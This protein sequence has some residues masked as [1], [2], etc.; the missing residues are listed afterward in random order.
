MSQLPF[1]SITELSDRLRRRE[2]RAVDV[3]SAMLERIELIDPSTKSYVHVCGD[4]AL[5]KADEADRQMDMGR[6]KGVLHGVPLGVKDL[7]HTTFAPTAAGGLVYDGF[8]APES[9][10][11]VSR[12]ETAGAILLGKLAMTEGAY[13]EHHPQ[14]QT[15]ANPWNSAYWTGVSSSGCGVAT[16]AGLCY[17]AIGSDTGGSIR[18]PCTANGLTGI[19]PTWGRVSRHG[20]F[21]LA[22]SLDHIGPMARSAADCA[23]ILEAI[24]GWDPRDPTTIKQPMEAFPQ[25]GL[26]GL[27]GVRIGLD[28]EQL[29]N[30]VDPEVAV[31]IEQALLVFESLGAQFVE[32][33]LPPCKDLAE[34]WRRLCAVETALEHAQSF[35]SEKA[36]YGHAL[37]A[38][39]EEG[40]SIGGL[41]VARGLQRRMQFSAALENLF[42][43]VDCLALPTIPMRLPSWEDM[44]S[45]GTDT[46][47]V[48]EL[49]RY[50][51]PLDF[52]G[53]PSVCFPVG[54]DS[55]GLPIG[56]Q[57]AGP[58][59]AE[60][61]LLHAVT[62]FQMQSDWHLR[63]PQLHA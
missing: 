9:A 63:H 61:R 24:A 11:V 44:A 41:E 13:A 48:T 34:A 54:C 20:T 7:L 31:S 43:I 4:H 51:A 37:R 50:T 39:I 30:G 14:L 49:M 46:D 6:W 60:V 16:A 33:T 47:W 17:G 35:D 38:L 12:L 19:K 27:G 23:A 56:M 57:L 2:I 26:T 10:T 3:T 59:L 52:S 18:F 55:A 42:E 62:A 15:P 22:E 32:V 8:M 53:T 25:P 5:A 28:R 36:L 40:R 1:L 29:S 45:F 21:A 58:K